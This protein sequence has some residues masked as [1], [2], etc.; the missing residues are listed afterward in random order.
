MHCMVFFSYL[1]KLQKF[2][3]VCL[4]RVS[5][6]VFWFGVLFVCV[7]WVFLF[8]SAHL[9]LCN[10]LAILSMLCKPFGPLG[11]QTTC[12]I[13]ALS[14]SELSPFASASK[15]WALGGM[16]SIPWAVLPG[17]KHP[18]PCREV[19]SH[20]RVPAALGSAV[21]PAAAGRQYPHVPLGPGVQWPLSACL[22]RMFLS[23]GDHSEGKGWKIQTFLEGKG[24]NL[25]K[26]DT[27][28][29]S[30][31]NSCACD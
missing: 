15:K 13:R 28:F 20:S 7:L 29:L 3:F 4:Y 19:P 9:A 30:V 6:M 21:C 1:A 12:C 23:P 26:H 16:G 10:R 11:H 5:W 17:P 25:E 22:W 27:F 14:K 24:V 2:F 18:T 8:S 31:L